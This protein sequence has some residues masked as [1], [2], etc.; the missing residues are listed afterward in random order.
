MCKTLKVSKSGYYYWCKGIIS[1]REKE[2]NKLL[3]II[4]II[5]NQSNGTYGSPRIQEELY[6]LGYKVSRPRI[7]RIM[8]SNNIQSKVRKKWVVTTNSK[9]ND[10]IAPNLLDRS[11]T[12]DLPGQIWV[13]DL[14]Y[15]NTKEGW[16]YLTVVID[17]FDRKVIGWALSNTMQAIQTSIAALKMALS[18]RD[19][20]ENLIFH[21]DRGVQYTC[22]DFT[23]IT[24][25]QNITQSMSR[26]GNCWDNA[27]AESFFKTIKTESI[28]RYNF[29]SKR[30]AKL[31]VF[32]YIEIWY[33][34]KRRHSSLNY[35]TP[36]EIENLF[37][38]KKTA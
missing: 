26:K 18:N 29:K 10:P 13:S 21:S 31:E 3:Q 15:I 38:I 8:K 19:K 17:L 6:R 14:T 5:Y 24:T 32:R 23:R 28:Y 4:R 27:V 30:E 1:N 35:A 22:K 2:N 9:H 11:F 20:S 37:N 36:L 16:L 12:V 34:R 7:A 25:K 33:N